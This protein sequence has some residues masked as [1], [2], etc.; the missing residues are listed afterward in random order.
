MVPLVGTLLTHKTV[1][2]GLDPERTFRRT[3]SS[4]VPLAH[5]RRLLGPNLWEREGG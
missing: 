2:S 1:D 3:T 5:R 4:T